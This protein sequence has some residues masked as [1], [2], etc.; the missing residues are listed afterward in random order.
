MKEK[1]LTLVIGFLIG[2]IVATGGFFIYDKV[3]ANNS[4][5][6]QNNSQQQMMPNG[7]QIP[8]MMQDGKGFKGGQNGVMTPPDMQTQEGENTEGTNNQKT[9]TNTNT[10]NPN[11]NGKQGVKTKGNFN[12]GQM[13]QNGET[14]PQM[15][16]DNQSDAT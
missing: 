15:P 6:V 2:A 5:N 13:K 3:R 7:G 9:E 8:Q 16:N 11:S 4:G 10:S 1:I 14:P 12:A